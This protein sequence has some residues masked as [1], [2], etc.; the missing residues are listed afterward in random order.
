M[1]NI[2][3][4]NNFYI[5][6]SSACVVDLTPPTFS[7]I[8]F[9]DV[10]SRGQIRAG[11]SAASD[12]TAPI[13]YEVYIQASTATGLFN[14]ANIA[15]I[16]NQLSLDIF[17]LPNG[18]FLVNGTTYF[19]GVRA[20]DALSNRDSNVASLNVISTG[21]LTSIDTY[22]TNASWSI[23]DNHNFR[24][25]AWSNKNG[26][27]AI[28]PSAVLGTASYQV[29]NKLG[30]HVIG[31]SG[32]GVSANANGLY[33]FPAVTN[34]L[35]EV[36]EH[37][38]VKVTVQVDGEDR[39]NY[40]PLFEGQSNY[41]I[42]GEF[43]INQSNNIIGSFWVERNEQVTTTSLGTGSYQ[44]Y[45]PD[46]TVFAGFSESGLSANL[47][48]FYVISQAAVPALY[49]PSLS[50][51][52]RFSVAVDGVVRSHNAILKAIPT[53]YTCKAVFSINASNQLES[54]FWATINDELV[55][56]IILGTASYQ[57]YDKS[58]TAVAGLSQ[59]GILKD[60]NG[61]Y[62]AAPVSAILITDLTHYTAVITLQIAGRNVSAAKGF[63]LLGT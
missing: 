23:N 57:I 31:M 44:V 4:N 8:N 42:N 58:G 53:V 27:L 63:T 52:V 47:D 17:T 28:S 20:L 6:T 25:T 43:S 16:T 29:Y 33:V 48:G 10:E 38:E 51:F 18:S 41:A 34:I 14:V 56:P 54:T 15:G 3:I 61:F 46:G 5:G 24:L 7:G 40:I 37:Y 22:E 62:H 2:L 19:V 39:V 49:D 30:N 1:S 60:A 59:I 32:S 11:W 55:N 45:N 26:S 21:V 13:R 50:Y 12:A 9:L 35:D 36:K